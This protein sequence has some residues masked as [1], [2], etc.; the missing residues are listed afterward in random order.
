MIS[1]TSLSSPSSDLCLQSPGPSP[2]LLC[3][4]EDTFSS[5]QFLAYG[6][7]CRE[8]TLDLTQQEGN[9]HCPTLGEGHCQPMPCTSCTLTASAP[10][11]VGTG[12]GILDMNSI[13]D[14]TN[15]DSNLSLT[16]PL[17]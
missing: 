14:P 6:V 10:S 13:P 7:W 12:V 8:G 4:M 5:G 1:W 11:Y 17:T 16:L 15:P 3:L 2:G 9:A